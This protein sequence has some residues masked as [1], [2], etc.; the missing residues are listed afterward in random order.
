MK[1]VHWGGAPAWRMLHSLDARLGALCV[2]AA[3]LSNSDIGMSTALQSVASDRY[4][5]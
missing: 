1:L 2:W 3:D 5:T 4:Q